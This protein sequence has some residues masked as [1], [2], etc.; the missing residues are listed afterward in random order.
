MGVIRKRNIKGRKALVMKK[1]LHTV[2]IVVF[3]LCFLTMVGCH[4]SRDDERNK[5]NSKED[6]IIDVVVDNCQ[7]KYLKHEYK[8]EWF[9]N[10]K[11]LLVYYQ[12][13]N[14]NEYEDVGCDETL[15]IK[16]L[17]YDKEIP[18]WFIVTGFYNQYLTET[19]T[20]SNKKIEPGETITIVEGYSLKNVS[21]VVLE[22]YECFD[23]EAKIHDSM[24]IT[25]SE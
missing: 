13:T 2:I 14:L 20:D 1:T 5:T 6:G 10:G 12:F 19:C 24:I 22:V 17:Q 15:F 16:G 3:F 11:T 21:N 18:R 23:F 7:I 4:W 9:G 25:L 8:E